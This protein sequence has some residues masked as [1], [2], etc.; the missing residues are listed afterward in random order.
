MS[1][2]SRSASP[3]IIR[4]RSKSSFENNSPTKVLSLI[5]IKNIDYNTT[6]KRYRQSINVSKSV[7]K[8]SNVNKAA[9]I[10]KKQYGT[11]RER[12]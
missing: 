11:Y 9:T 4:D 6:M 1:D 2:L 12:L 7:L 5:D 3:S 10:D 8:N